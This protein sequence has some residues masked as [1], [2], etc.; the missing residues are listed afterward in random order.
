M[1]WA[2]LDLGGNQGRGEH[3]SLWCNPSRL[4]PARTLSPLHHQ[5]AFVIFRQ[6]VIFFSLQS[7][8]SYIYFKS[9][10]ISATLYTA[11]CRLIIFHIAMMSSQKKR[12]IS[13]TRDK[14]H[15]LLFFPLPTLLF[16]RE[17]RRGGHVPL[18]AFAASRRWTLTLRQSRGEEHMA[19]AGYNRRREKK[20]SEIISF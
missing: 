16:F 4:D 15:L 10:N 7:I 8:C 2:L 13:R 14:Q 12:S 9:I 5:S 11:C 19:R 1:S 18:E 6:R 17:R 20:V 3:G